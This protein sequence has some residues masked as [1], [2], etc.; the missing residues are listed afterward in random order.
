ME[1]TELVCILS[2]KAAPPLVVE[3]PH[4]AEHSLTWDGGGWQTERFSGQS[5]KSRL[6][7]LPPLQRL[8]T[9]LN[10]WQIQVTLQL[11]VEAGLGCICVVSCSK[12]FS[13]QTVHKSWRGI[14][15]ESLS[16]CWNLCFTSLF[17]CFCHVMSSFFFQL[18]F[19]FL[20][21]LC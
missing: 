17:H 6:I 9:P 11:S 19:C 13:I 12:K 8:G 3:D 10:H 18:V 5:L 16:F 7:S 4:L 21:C 14:G 1:E 2:R 15:L 20:Y